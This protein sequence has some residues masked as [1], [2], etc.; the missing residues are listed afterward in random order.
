MTENWREGR[1]IIIPIMWTQ[2]GRKNLN[3]LQNLV[4]IFFIG[5]QYCYLKDNCD[6]E[7]LCKDVV[8]LSI[9]EKI[10]YILGIKNIWWLYE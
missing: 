2:S 3:E 1:P 9:A 5:S 8:F 4:G 6:V 7:H 10:A